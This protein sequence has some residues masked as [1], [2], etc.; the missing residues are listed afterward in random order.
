MNERKFHLVGIGGVGMSGLAQILLEQGYQVSGSDMRENEFTKNL[1]SQGAQVYI[2]HAHQN[3]KDAE[4]VIYSSAISENNPEMLAAR[5]KG[6][7]TMKRQEALAK[8]MEGKICI[9]VTGA[10]GKTTTTSLLSC[11]LIEAG[12]S[13]TVCIGACAFNIDGNVYLGRGSYFLVEADESDGTF[14]HLSPRYA[15]IT[16]IDCEHLDYYGSI[17]KIKK[18][19][20]QFIN[21]I[22]GSGCVLVCGDDPNIRDIL[23]EFSCR[24][25]TFGLSGDCQLRAENLRMNSSSS[26]FLCKNGEETL[27]EIF[28]NATGEHNVSNSLACI[29]LGIELDITFQTI[30]RAL[31]NYHGAQRRFQVIAQAA[32]V[33]VVDDYAHHPTE[34]KATLR[35]A[36][37]WPIRRLIVVFQPHRYTRTRLILDRFGDCFALA[38]YLIITDIYSAWEAPIPG[39]SAQDICREVEKCGLNKEVH[40]LPFKDVGEHLLRIVQEGDMILV[41]GAGN[42]T[43]I[44]HALVAR[45]TDR[46]QERV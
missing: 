17:E 28:L 4:L 46:A 14:L 9:A 19:F 16:N 22:D 35:A 21:K 39:V 5:A 11:L 43:E 26:T 30:Q 38:D 13:P 27:G 1:R 25:I 31:S 32:G 7:R 20:I 6:I 44:S 12:L 23:R 42:I 2:G 8:I 37:N 18:S 36:R 45:L 33:V 41:L 29:G 10:H 40:F 3:L 24:V 34:I 15:V